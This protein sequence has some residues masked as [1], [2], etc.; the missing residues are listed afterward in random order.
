MSLHGS[1]SRLVGMLKAGNDAAAPALWD[2]FCVRLARLAKKKLRHVSRRVQDEEDIA[3]SAFKSLC[4][5]ARSGRFPRLEN[6]ES[7]W[8]LLAFI[9]AQ[10]AANHIAYE[11][12]RK[13]GSGQVRGARP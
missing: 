8:G 6:R 7:L 11:R 4:L 2:R 13:R 3:L 12:R 5:G 1:V 9:T 10:K